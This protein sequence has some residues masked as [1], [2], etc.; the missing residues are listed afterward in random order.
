MA[1]P[2]PDGFRYEE[3]GSLALPAGFRYEDDTPQEPAP[4]QTSSLLRRAGDVPLGL[5][6][7]TIGLPEAIL[8]AADIVT[9]GYA[10]KGAE[11]LG[12]RPKEA[13]EIINS[14]QSPELNQAR[15]NVQ[16]TKGFLPTVGAMVQN[17]STIVDAALES[18]PSMIGGAGVAR[19][20]MKLAPRI[21]G[22]VAA[23]LGEGIVSAGQTA[24]QVRQE[25]PDGTLGLKQM[26]APVVSGA[27]T[28]GLGIA[29][30]KIAQKLG[31]ADIDTMLAT[32]T[33]NPKQGGLLKRVV[34]GMFSEGILEELPQSAQEQAAQNIAL[35]KP[36]NEGVAEAAASGMLVG[37]IMGGGGNVLASGAKPNAI[38]T[39]L[40]AR[41]QPT[42]ETVS[43]LPE[44]PKGT[45]E[46]ALSA[47]TPAQTYHDEMTTALNPAAV[48]TPVAMPEQ[49][50]DIFSDESMAVSRAKEP[51]PIEKGE[52][53]SP[54]IQPENVDVATGEVF[55]ESPVTV[56]LKGLPTKR[57]ARNLK[58]MGSETGLK[59]VMKQF[60]DANPDQL[61]LPAEAQEPP[62]ELPD[63]AQTNYAQFAPQRTE[64][65][66]GV[67]DI[68]EG[69][70]LVPPLPEI[71]T[72]DA[73]DT[74]APSGVTQTADVPGVQTVTEPV[75]PV[76]ATGPQDV[77]ETVPRPVKAIEDLTD[78]EI[79]A[80]P[81]VKIDHPVLAALKE[82]ANKAPRPEVQETP[83]VNYRTADET[84]RVSDGKGGIKSGE[85]FKTSSGRMTTPFPKQK[86]QKYLT[87]W[88]IDNAVAE[89]ESRGDK[90]NA[91]IFKNTTQLKGGNLTT[92]DNDSMHM[93]LYGEQ[94]QVPRPFLK[95]LVPT[96]SVNKPTIPTLKGENKPGT[97]EKGKADSEL[98]KKSPKFWK[99]ETYRDIAGKVATSKDVWVR[100]EPVYSSASLGKEPVSTDYFLTDGRRSQKISKAVADHI[101][102]EKAKEVPKPSRSAG[103]IKNAHTP[104]TLRAAFNKVVNW[105]KL[106]KMGNFHIV[107]NADGLPEGAKFSDVKGLVTANGQVYFV[108][109]QI[110]AGQE[111][112]ILEHEIAVHVMKL[113][114]TD[115]EFQKILSIWA[116][117]KKEGNRKVMEAYSM[118][119]KDTPSHLVD[120]ES[121]G[122]ASELF[123]EHMMVHR[124]VAW[125]RRM[126]RKIGVV[127]DYN[128]SEIR[129]MARDALLSLRDV[130]SPFAKSM[131]DGVNG[132]PVSDSERSSVISFFDQIQEF[133]GVVSPS[134][135][136]RSMES[137]GDKH[138]SESTRTATENLSNLL[139]RQPRI[140]QN[141]SSLDINTQSLVMDGMRR[142]LKNRKILDSVIR[143]IPVDMMDVLVSKQL[144]A[145]ML[146][147]DKP[148]FVN[149]SSIDR[150]PG[151]H[152]A[153]AF[154]DTGGAVVRL[155]LAVSRTI[156][157]S[158]DD[159]GVLDSEILSAKLA[160][161]K[162]FSHLHDLLQ[163]DGLFDSTIYDN[164]SLIK[165]DYSTITSDYLYGANS[166]IR[167]SRS[168]A[169]VK[170][171][172][173]NRLQ[174]TPY[175]GRVLTSVVDSGMVVSRWGRSV[176]TM[177]HQ[178]VQ[179]EFKNTFGVVYR[180][181]QQFISDIARFAS[182]AEALA[183]TIFPKTNLF[184]GL[185]KF[186]SKEDNALISK[187]L[188]EGTLENGPSPLN[189]VI[190]SDEQLQTKY[191][192]KKD[193]PQYKMY[194]EALAA[195]NRSL[196]DMARSTMYGVVMRTGEHE[197]FR[198]LWEKPIAE[199]ATIMSDRIQGQ[200]DKLAWQPLQAKVDAKIALDADEKKVFAEYEKLVGFQNSIKKIAVTTNK[201]QTHGYFPLSRFGD[202]TV[203]VRKMEAGKPSKDVEYFGQY[204]SNHAAVMAMKELQRLYPDHDIVKSPT[205]KEAHKLYSGLTLEAVELF[206]EH[207]NAEEVAPYQEY[208]K[209][210]MNNRSAMKHMIHRKGTAGYNTDGV[211][212][213]ANFIYS[214]SRFTSKNMNMVHMRDA[215]AAMK[216]DDLK[217]TALRLVEYLNNPVDEASRLRGFL[218][219]QYLG[220][221]IA[222]GIT[223]LTQ[224]PL[225]LVPYLNQYAKGT[226]VAKA[227]GKAWSMAL[228]DVN[229][230]GDAELRKAMLE[231]QEEGHTEPQEIHQLTATASNRLG[232]SNPVWNAALKSW[233][234]IFSVTEVLNRKTS[235]IAAFQIAKINGKD[236]AEA[237]QAAIEAIDATQGVYNKG[238]RPEWARGVTGATLFTFKQFSVMYLELFMRLPAKQKLV[239]LGMLMLMAGAEGLPFAGDL[240]DLIDT[241]GQWFGYSTNSKRAFKEFAD[242]TLGKD[243]SRFMR[244]GIS[245]FAPI[246]VQGRL[247]AQN[248][249]PGTAI[250][251]QSSTDKTRDITEFFGPAGGLVTAV[252]DA[253]ALFAKGELARGAKALASRAIQG[254]ATGV[255]MAA[256]GQATDKYGRKTFDTTPVEALYKG[257][258]FNPSR[259]A[260]ESRTKSNM[261]QDKKL[262]E[263]R[264]DEIVT[265]WAQAII[266]KD[267]A[268][269]QDA[270][271]KWRRWNKENPEMR[272]SNINNSVT[273]KVKSIRMTSAERF[274]KSMPKEQRK[275]AMSELSG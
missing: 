107:E 156:N 164:S 69:R 199:I 221:S 123:P 93:Y 41:T 228:G 13:K 74:S 256:T 162:G 146:L 120:E 97:V 86:G 238:N 102:E 59:M 58:L 66:Q 245:A 239:M 101:S 121:L 104:D 71:A 254:V 157:S 110:A 49:E 177:Y 219:I 109:D 89:A 119:P 186:V 17:P 76:S 72:P 201:L 85:V 268:G 111:T 45:L 91:S 270:I 12:F 172:T 33:L 244:E 143:L 32:G 264:K 115:A 24:E 217:D 153:N 98:D 223:N 132:H 117:L 255:E 200:I 139:K 236:Y 65:T 187:A 78:A 112:G 7:G 67:G 145:K 215:A 144:S 250:L 150:V 189:G 131:T 161:G 275:A 171:D 242:K 247:G 261:M 246:D 128:Y 62:P 220:G 16:N 243:V 105:A 95:P 20:A 63:I 137:S 94:P 163:K 133:V 169:D 202:F 92:A 193:S 64:I 140:A 147:H 129:V 52:V 235:A 118:V 196:E 22:A 77:S 82:S 173:F 87:Q 36:W 191:G 178:S 30:G 100:E 237:K 274:K 28:A 208:L 25:T 114:K 134:L 205:S 34:E 10:G 135:V 57:R 108:A 43:P 14:W 195:T 271:A 6:K 1:L 154:I 31:I 174:E 141:L 234:S 158:F 210:A 251:K 124:F 170:A 61:P 138:L 37:G 168:I 182:K 240:E 23:G 149:S 155:I 122:Y 11:S 42:G 190:W 183:P 29:G 9:G 222:S 53:T 60:Y 148:V 192:I 3:Q 106:E 185:T 262:F 79:A 19:G 15:Q 88:I 47:V 142:S 181:G 232:A 184:N 224:V 39:D 35:N 84:G 227:V 160:L 75:K 175:L 260:E 179:P 103:E 50:E 209:K 269:K 5:L 273:R 151:N 263:V 252:G 152:I 212:T 267:A 125:F 48:E 2:L 96:E 259:M 46:K 70:N 176:G 218:F 56:W 203:T 272:M 241:F 233:G 127:K 230:I 44:A 180:R 198:D 80:L 90:W 126:L 54:L 81:E 40:T 130:N 136:S 116:K 27:L 207:M 8:G 73:S 68:V 21:G 249:I 204:E 253:L 165:N 206:A 159:T 229:K 211:R 167:Y 51:Q 213:L 248:L 194:N 266:A 226:D 99:G 214:N 166:D 258:G 55:D 83:A 18:A 26:I 257:I 4:Q 225:M 188:H 197:D 265:Q 38:E 113:G 231:L 216:S